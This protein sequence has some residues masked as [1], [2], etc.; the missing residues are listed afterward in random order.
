MP[1]PVPK[2]RFHAKVP[3]PR[4]LRSMNDK[5]KR[6]GREVDPKSSKDSR[7][8]ERKFSGSGCIYM[9]L[10][11][12]LCLNPVVPD[13]THKNLLNFCSV[14]DGLFK[15]LIEAQASFA[16]R[17]HMRIKEEEI[18]HTIVKSSPGSLG[19]DVDDARVFFVD[20]LNQIRREFPGHEEVPISKAFTGKIDRVIECTNC[21]N[22]TRSTEQC[23]DLQLEIPTQSSNSR[24]NQ[25]AISIGSLVPQFFDTQPV[26]CQKCHYAQATVHRS[27]S[28]L[29]EVIVLCLKRFSSSPTG[30]YKKHRAPITI[31]ATL[32]FTQFC[33]EEAFVHDAESL[34]YYQDDFGMRPH[35]P[36]DSLPS[37]SSSPFSSVSPR[38]QHD[39][40]R[41]SPSPTE[42]Y[43]AR[44]KENDPFG[45]TFDDPIV[46][47]SDDEDAIIMTT[48]Q[49]HQSFSFYE[50]PTEEEQYQ[51]AME[52]SIRASQLTSSQTSI[53]EYKLE[54]KE[55]I[56]EIMSSQ[57]F[58]DD[59]PF[60]N[61]NFASMIKRE[62]SSLSGSQKSSAHSSRLGT[63]KISPK[64]ELPNRR[65]TFVVHED[66]EKGIG[67]DSN[68]KDNISDDGEEDD[69]NIKAALLA[70]LM[71]IGA[72]IEEQEK[73]QVEEAIR[74]SLLDQEENKEN[75]S[76]EKSHSKKKILEKKKK[77]VV[78]ERSIS[79]LDCSPLD[80]R[81]HRHQNHHA[82]KKVLPAQLKR[83][84]TIDFTDRHGFWGHNM[85]S[86]PKHQSFS[87][88]Q[89]PSPMETSSQ[90]IQLKFPPKA[91][92]SNSKTRQHASQNSDV[93]SSKSAFTTRRVTRASKGKDRASSKTSAMEHQSLG[94][95][96][97]QAIVSHTS[98]SSSS[99]ATTGNKDHYIC[100]QLGMDGIWRSNDGTKIR[101]MGT[102][103][104]DINQY[105]A[106]SGYLFFYVRSYPGTDIE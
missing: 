59:N 105:R 35:I 12:M 51:W 89:S 85:D 10:L 90:P 86:N 42:R 79:Q 2:P 36:S 1:E 34:L 40:F 17:K 27:L 84:N 70:S 92:Q 7:V 99:P 68:D 62:S 96:K 78:L 28:Q 98:L 64:I 39:L 46:L 76:P 22:V 66:K 61:P 32:E 4:V 5:S 53:A 11:A 24:V 88:S 72:D 9:S 18:S 95:F 60:A 8:L 100:D 37:S 73:R 91:R 49:I 45:S 58:D 25:D 82:R 56:G 106:R 94:L 47:D 87:L 3:T 38:G 44:L 75:I 43:M 30:G 15:S 29:P 57:I 81:H 16:E 83:S 52:E 80:R 41:S 97:L 74:L 65:D 23:Q 55:D 101:R 104:S 69:E 102:N 19:G 31:D 20:C 93:N 48:P 26:E 13:L 14:H 6:Y 21:G 33:S 103:I 54:D 50:A 71:P 77:E 67:R 63:P